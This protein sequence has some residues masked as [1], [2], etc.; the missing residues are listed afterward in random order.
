MYLKMPC[1]HLA[2]S[3]AFSRTLSLS[4]RFDEVSRQYEYRQPRRGKKATLLC[5]D[6]QLTLC[7]P[8]STNPFLTA[9]MLK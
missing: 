8:S 2:R 6:G 1:S 3:A 7:S 4:V 5:V 9:E